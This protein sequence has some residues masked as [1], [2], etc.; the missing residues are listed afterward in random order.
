MFI[1]LIEARYEQKSKFP[2]KGS[3]MTTRVV[4]SFVVTDYLETALESVRYIK[5]AVKQREGRVAIKDYDAPYGSNN[6]ATV[7]ME[8]RDGN[9]ALIYRNW[10][11]GKLTKDEG[12]VITWEEFQRY[13]F[14]ILDSIKIDRQNAA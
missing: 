14:T 10:D 1:A 4:E 12:R 6:L 13:Y 7:G 2:G 11:N 9:K 8:Y 3:Y 5:W